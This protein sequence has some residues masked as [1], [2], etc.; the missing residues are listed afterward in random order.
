MNNEN[1]SRDDEDLEAFL[2]RQSSVTTDYGNLE[3]VEPPPAVDEKVLAAAKA[4]TRSPAAKPTP[5]AAPVKPAATPAEIPAATK[6]LPPTQAGGP[7]A[8]RVE[9]RK[10]VREPVEVDDEPLPVRR[11]RWLIPAVLAAS[12]L[13]AVGVGVNLLEDA[14][15]DIEDGSGTGALTAKRARE[16][17][18]AKKAAAD[19]SAQ[20]SAEEAVAV[21]EAEALPPPPMFE[22]EGPQVQDLN[23][24]IALIRK[25]LVLA[26]Q[27]AAATEVAPGRPAAAAGKLADSPDAAAPAVPAASSVIQPRDRRLTKILELFDGGSVDLAA[28]SLEIFLRDF[29]DDPISQRILAVKP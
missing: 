2:A 1:T 11:P 28:D 6:P 24:A 8:S 15:V 7:E 5:G 19:A 26:N 29:E 3:L 20:A 27:I 14:P 13:V 10:R 12:V 18:E 22:P 9:R 25:E 21:P 4:S 23:A 17:N 16:R